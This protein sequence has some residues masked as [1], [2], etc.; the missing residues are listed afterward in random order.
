MKTIL[1]SLFLIGAS[2]LFS[3]QVIAQETSPTIEQES[4]RVLSE[5]KFK[6]IEA[7]VYAQDDWSPIILEGYSKSELVCFY[8]QSYSDDTIA[9][10]VDWAHKKIHNFEESKPTSHQERKFQKIKTLPRTRE[11]VYDFMMEMTTVQIE[12]V[13]Y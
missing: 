5:E 13:G 12:T 11:N 1:L 3:N 8:I 7:K 4:Y 2:A 9:T 6:E 10:W